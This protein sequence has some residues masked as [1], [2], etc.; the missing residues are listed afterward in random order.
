MM[1][2]WNDL[3][4]PHLSAFS[5]FARFSQTLT[6]NTTP[7]VILMNGQLSHKE[8]SLTMNGDIEGVMCPMVVD[9]GANVTV[10]RPG[11]LSKQTLSSLGATK[12]LLKI[13]T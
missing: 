13:A 3:A 11:V 6:L 5:D 8:G 12:R 10:V 2:V 1:L 9:A 4:D 7:Q